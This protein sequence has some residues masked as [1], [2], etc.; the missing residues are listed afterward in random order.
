M[1]ASSFEFVEIIAYATMDT[2]QQDLSLHKKLQ[3]NCFQLAVTM[4]EFD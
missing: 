1:R 4:Y 2:L 3:K